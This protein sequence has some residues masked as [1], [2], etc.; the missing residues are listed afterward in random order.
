M[1]TGTCTWIFHLFHFVDFA[2][3]T[4][5]YHSINAVTETQNFFDKFFISL[6]LKS[7]WITQVGITL[8][9]LP[10]ILRAFS[11]LYHFTFFCFSAFV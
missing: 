5:I 11:S 10:M 8:P 4:M 9:V 2:V 1:F 7:K 3:A 6:Q